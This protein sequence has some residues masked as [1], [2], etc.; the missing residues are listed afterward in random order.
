MDINY[1]AFAAS[2]LDEVVLCDVGWPGCHL[3]TLIN[4][5]ILDV[6]YGCLPVQIFSFFFPPRC[7]NPVICLNT[8]RDCWPFSSSFFCEPPPPYYFIIKYI[9]VKYS[10]KTTIMLYK[11][12]K[13]RITLN[14]PHT[15]FM[16][17]RLIYL[18]LLSATWHIFALWWV[19]S[20]LW[21]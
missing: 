5:L 11:T 18:H 8:Q 16:K 17:I 20:R 10:V 7:H 3:M 12:D 19:L 15:F 4:F 6:F 21:H 2:F 13:R 14:K 9:C 1:C